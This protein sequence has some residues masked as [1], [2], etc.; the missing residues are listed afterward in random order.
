M[1]CQDSNIILYFFPTEVSG[2]MLGS[3]MKYIESSLNLNYTSS[4]DATLTVAQLI[5]LVLDAS[6]PAQLNNTETCQLISSVTSRAPRT[7][8]RLPTTN[9]AR[10]FTDVTSWPNFDVKFGRPDSSTPQ[11][12]F[13]AL[14]WSSLSKAWCLFFLYG[15]PYCMAAFCVAG[16]WHEGKSEVIRMNTFASEC[17][18]SHYYI[19]LLCELRIYCFIDIVFSY[20]NK[21]KKKYFL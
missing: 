15:S 17:L 9:H 6:A 19:E 13:D 18:T 21:V 20:L 16:S 8:R 10:S 14:W 3:Y 2:K 11:K 1:L 12:L 7:C 4:V 5:Y